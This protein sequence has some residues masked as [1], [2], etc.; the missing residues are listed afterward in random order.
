MRNLDFFFSPGNEA[1]LKAAQLDLLV[2]RQNACL[3][4]IPYKMTLATS[5]AFPSIAL[6]GTPS[7]SIGSQPDIQVN[8]FNIFLL[9][10]SNVLV[11]HTRRNRIKSHHIISQTSKTNSETKMIYVVS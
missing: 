2:K 7:D 10:I 1:L 3:G 9:E 4:G 6:S 8:A 11:S 5:L